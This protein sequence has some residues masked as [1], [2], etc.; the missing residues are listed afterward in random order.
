MNG[1]DNR[2]GIIGVR[3]FNVD[4]PASLRTLAMGSLR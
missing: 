3:L 4:V 1:L 2:Y